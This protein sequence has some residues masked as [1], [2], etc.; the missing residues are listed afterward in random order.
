MVEYRR[1]SFAR[2][3]AGHDCGSVFIILEETGE[4]VVLADGKS[5]TLEKPKKKKKKHIQV[6]YPGKETLSPAPT[7]EEIRRL[8]R[9][10]VCEDA[11][12]EKIR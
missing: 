11:A 3:L 4:Y 6:M 7:N 9:E 8:I 1:G 5:R 12:R 2:S 10:A